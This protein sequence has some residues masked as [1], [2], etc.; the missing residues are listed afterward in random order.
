MQ[1]VIFRTAVSQF[2]LCWHANY[3]D[4]RYIISRA[5]L[6]QVLESLPLTRTKIKPLHRYSLEQLTR[7]APLPESEREKL[8]ALDLTPWVKLAGNLGEVRVFTFTKWGGFA[9][10]HVHL[11]WPHHVDRTEREDVVPYRCGIQF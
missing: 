8:R 11:R 6:E 3:Y 1:W 2:H 10:R 5:G 9:W 4:L 7:G